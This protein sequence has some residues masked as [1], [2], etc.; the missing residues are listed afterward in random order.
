MQSEIIYVDPD[1]GFQIEDDYYEEPCC[2]PCKNSGSI[3]LAYAF[4]DDLFFCQVCFEK[5][6]NKKL[7]FPSSLYLSDNSD[8]PPM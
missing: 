5:Y 3:T 6:L 2:D 8:L 4:S 7:D 1:G